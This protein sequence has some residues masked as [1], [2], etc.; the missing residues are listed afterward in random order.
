[1]LLAYLLAGFY[2]AGCSQAVIPPSETPQATV[3]P[4][5]RASVTPAPGDPAQ[6]SATP[7]Q[8]T[9][10]ALLVAGERLRGVK[11]VFWHFFQD[12]HLTPLVRAFNSDNPW[13]IQ[14]EPRRFSESTELIGALAEE[15][16]GVPKPAI[17]SAYSDQLI[18]LYAQETLVALNPF[19]E[20]TEWGLSAA[21]QADFYPIFWEQDLTRDVRLGLPARRTARFLLVNQTWAGE[22]GYRTLPLSSQQFRMQ[23][24]AANAAM[25]MDADLSNDAFGGWL[26]DTQPVTLLGWI[27]AFGGDVLTTSGLS[28]RFNTPQTEE[29]FTF[30]KELID[31]NCAF[32]TLDAYPDEA[33]ASRKALMVTASLVDLP[34]ITQAFSEAENDDKWT[35]FPFPSPRGQATLPVYGPS[36]AL[37]Q[38]T[39]EEQLA[40]WLFARWLVSSEA[41]AFWTRLAGDFPVRLS[42]MDMLD[43]YALQNPQWSMAKEH[44]QRGITEPDL[45]TWGSVQ[46]ALGDAGTQLF[47]SYFTLDRIA[48]TLE[49]LDRTAREL[50]E[51]E[52]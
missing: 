17:L 22:L 15:A 7:T 41:Q 3:T 10:P 20:S 30:L 6:P 32:S 44:I 37:T 9:P 51:R 1:M 47:R 45:P 16:T 33:F 4:T 39:P 2:L 21:E 24:C 29:A 23:S 40:A 8:P 42:A 5:A 31:A 48:A 43:D 18:A 34:F 38:A 28:Y 25:K 14:V 36:L 13:D 46:W 35:A 26:V 27:T 11:V 52:R 19:L 12:D 50:H 49:E